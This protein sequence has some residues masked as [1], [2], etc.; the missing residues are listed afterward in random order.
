MEISQSYINMYTG[1]MGVY[2]EDEQAY[3]GGI[4]HNDGQGF[5][6]D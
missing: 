5:G 2:F 3:N 1:G 4:L 6:Y